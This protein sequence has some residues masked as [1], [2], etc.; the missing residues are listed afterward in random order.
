MAATAGA[1]VLALGSCSDG[2]T[3]SGP[4]I[5][6]AEPEKVAA[7]ALSKV[8]TEYD[9]DQTASIESGHVASDRTGNVF[10]ADDSDS[11]VMPILRVTPDGKV[12]QFAKV[13]TRSA[14][15][16]LAAAPDGSL[17]TGGHDGLSR[18]SSEGAVTSLPSTHTFDLPEPIGVRPD[19]TIIVTE[20]YSVWSL[21]DG[22]ADEIFSFPA[23]Q[24]ASHG[25]VAADGTVYATNGRLSNLQVLAPGRPPKTLT[26][27]G[28]LPGAGMPLSDMA[29]EGMT[30]AGDGG[31]YARVLKDPQ[32][33]PSTYVYLVHIDPSGALTAMARG[34]EEAKPCP[35]G[36]QYPALDNPCELPW[37][38]ARSG[39][40]LLAL[41]SVVGRVHTPPPALAMRAT[42][43]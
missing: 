31:L 23:N 21:K 16:G 32:K 42:Y 13:K 25:T 19:G 22:K 20:N 36:Q 3:E 9:L 17:V 6:V 28:S 15:S 18:V 7:F 29:F 27:R 1:L 34:F 4:R 33:G 38:L 43:K 2:K 26:V 14:D 8:S 41:G 30:P 12:S 39:D 35:A 10:L 37:F 24:G 5:P 40:Q 11:P